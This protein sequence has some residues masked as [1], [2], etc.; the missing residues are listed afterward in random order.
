MKITVSDLNDTGRFQLVDTIEHDNI[1]AWIRPF[2]F[3]IGAVTVLY[4]VLNCLM[5]LFLAFVWTQ[6]SLSFIDFFS[7]LCLGMVGGWLILLPL[8]ENIHAIAYRWMGATDVRVHYKLRR[9]TAHCVANNQV[10]S[11]KQFAI[12]ALAPFIVIN[13]LLAILICFFPPGKL[14]LLLSGTLLAHLGACS[15]DVGFV[16]YLWRNR[17]RTLF[18]YDDAT[19]PR[20]YFFARKLNRK[21]TQSTG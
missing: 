14:L 10:L 12:V 19:M 15:G 17:S 6:A 20:T 18:T 7:T 16:Q 9:V 11:S 21:R 3:T 1:H 2:L 8:H 5:L 4:W 13:T